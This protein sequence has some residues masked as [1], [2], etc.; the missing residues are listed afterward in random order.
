MSSLLPP[1][2]WQCC[3]LCSQE[4]LRSEGVELWTKP[5]ELYQLSK[6]LLARSAAS[7]SSSLLRQRN[8]RSSRPTT[9]SRLLSSWPSCSENRTSW[10]YAST[11]TQEYPIITKLTH[12]FWWL[13]T[14]AL[15]HCVLVL[16]WDGDQTSNVSMAV[17][18][19]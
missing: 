2:Q 10:A 9:A 1:E 18:S 7:R 13:H 4:C 3:D 8:S 15:L 6:S 19:K 5:C 17:S 12:S 14:E 11:C 16:L